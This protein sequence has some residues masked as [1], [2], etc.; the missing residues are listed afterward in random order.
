MKYVQQTA[1]FQRLI[2]NMILSAAIQYQ[3]ILQAKKAFVHWVS[4]G[5]LYY[6]VEYII[7]RD[8]Y[9]LSMNN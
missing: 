6:F 1:L 8:Q 4:E 2:I 3:V 5:I 9:F 7:I